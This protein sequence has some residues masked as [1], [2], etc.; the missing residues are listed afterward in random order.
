MRARR[1]AGV[2]VRRPGARR[3]ARRAAGACR[4]RGEPSS[5]MEPD[6]EAD[7]EIMGG[8]E[9]EEEVSCAWE[10]RE[11]ARLLA[12]F[13]E[14]A[15]EVEPNLEE[16]HLGA[17]AALPGQAGAAPPAKENQPPRQRRPLKRLYRGDEE[18]EELSG[19]F[20]PSAG[21]VGSGS[22]RGRRADDDLACSLS[23]EGG[24]RMQH[25]GD[26][27]LDSL[28]SWGQEAHGAGSAGGGSADWA[29]AG[30]LSGG[31]GAA[32]R[33][34]PGAGS[35]RQVSGAARSDSGSGLQ[36]RVPPQ[37]SMAIACCLPCALCG[38]TLW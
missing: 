17:S 22:R 20:Q 21:G 16:C 24:Q 27:E 14:T 18:E 13:Q 23:W 36:V 32:S 35:G 2:R 34:L 31:A 37:A 4:A 5:S 7:V 15:V 25:R 10:E 28:G 9:D 8:S 29:R 6:C 19:S 11:E 3:R 30:Q 26:A 33:Q 12:A 38:E 1:G